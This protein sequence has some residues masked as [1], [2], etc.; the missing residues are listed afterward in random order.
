[1]WMRDLKGSILCLFTVSCLASCHDVTIDQ[2][3]GLEH[4]G[5]RKAAE[6]LRMV[7]DT[8]YCPAGMTSMTGQWI[9]RDSEFIFLDEYAVGIKHFSLDGS[10]TKESV[11]KGR[12]PG[13][14]LAESW[15]SSWDKG[16]QLLYVNDANLYIQVFDR[17]DSL[18]SYSH[19]SWII[20]MDDY[21]DPR[22][23]KARESNPDL[24]V[25]Q[26]YDYNFECERIVA[27][28]GRLFV[29][30]LSEH[31]KLNGYEKSRGAKRYWREARVLLS[32]DPDSVASTK[33]LFGRYPKAY[34][35]KNIP[36]FATY[37]FFIEEDHIHLAFAA[38]P[39]IYVLDLEGNPVYSYGEAE[40]GI[41]LMFPQTTSF[42]DYDSAFKSQRMEHGHYCRICN[43]G[44]Y[45]FRTCYLDSGEW[46][47][48]VYRG[49]DLVEVFDCGSDIKIIGYSGNW[50]Y[51]YA[52]V[53]F[54]NERFM[55]IKFQL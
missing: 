38:D 4:H 24:A 33:L 47:L 30:V 20:L 28:R 21:Y 17:E 1:M 29:P 37:D 11:R 25:P 5:V 27:S 23:W 48:Q 51:A 9:M 26:I 55:L 54:K 8:I 39:S 16:K 34:Q 7:A 35:T 2:Y 50:F 52:G 40:E 15:S 19:D 43:Y 18:L 41:E 32:F 6:V 44:G 53:D 14:V 49:V 46:R 12:G 22:Q 3:Y 42:E 10:F 45:T 31:P 36:I 13:E